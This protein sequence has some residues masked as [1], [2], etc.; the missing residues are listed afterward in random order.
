MQIKEELF[1]HILPNGL[2]IVLRRTPS[3]VAHVGVMVGAGT[4]DEAE[5]E[6]GMAHYI[7]HCVFKGT[8]HHTARQI[9]DHIEGFGGEINAYTTKEETTFYAATPV[10]HV[11]MT[12]RLI[13]EMVTCPTFPR[14]ETD[15]E[16]TVIYDEI[17][18]YNDSPSELIYDDF[19]SLIFDGHPLALPILGTKKSLRRIS[20][21]PDNPLRWM[22]THYR[23]DRMVVFAQGNIRPERFVRLSEQLFGALTCPTDAP[24]ARLTPLSPGPTR[25]A[26]YH[27]HTHQVHTMIGT[28]AYPLGHDDQLRFYLINNILGG[29][30]LNSRLNLAMREKRGLVYQVDA[31]YT[32]LSDTGY[33]CAY[34]ACE[35]EHADECMELALRELE[36][37]R[38]RA[39]TTTALRRALTQLRGQMAIASLNQENNVLSMAKSVLYHGHAPAWQETYERIAR[40]T[41]D[42]IL[43]IAGEIW[44]P[45]A[46]FTLTYS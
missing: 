28:R 30:A 45:D 35:R 10:S 38:T 39:L 17:E 42:D 36:R 5:G 46:L 22:R 8:A 23:A 31:N 44:Q 24:T 4:R 34:W 7:E 2:K 32:P 3:E 14:T 26:D 13:A 25:T 40:T 33:W 6:N 21:S 37:M 43:R 11:Q 18:S 12:L 16:R 27:R 29:G 1:Y 41:P 15:K 19:E 20:S 9:I